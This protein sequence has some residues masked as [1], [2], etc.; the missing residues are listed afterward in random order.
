MARIYERVVTAFALI[1]VSSLTAWSGA[2]IV[3][4]IKTEGEVASH[5]AD[6]TALAS[7]FDTPALAIAARQAAVPDVADLADTGQVRRRLQE[8]TAVLAVRP[9]SPVNWLSLASAR[10]LTGEPFDKVIAALSMS[11][12][13]GPNEGTVMSQRGTF[14]LW[15]W[16]SLPASMRESTMKDLAGAMLGGTI[17]EEERR[18]D[19]RI[20]STKGTAVRREIASMLRARGV[21]AK[22]LVR[23]VSL[24]SDGE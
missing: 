4:F 7:W 18:A 11:S 3:G 8:L 15:Q 21:P 10:L 1:V 19:I 9:L 17:S 20:L 12:V 5:K 22:E 6:A 2:N 13:T 16:E 23:W 14:G 24:Q